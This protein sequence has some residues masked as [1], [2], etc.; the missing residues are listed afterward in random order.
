M[1]ATNG[2]V[3]GRLVRGK[4]FRVTAEDVCGMP[5]TTLSSYVD[6][7]LITV[8]ATKNEDSGDEIKVRIVDGT[9]DT[10]EPGQQTLLNFGIKIQLSKVDPGVITMLTGD[11]ATMNSNTVPLIDGWEEQAL[12]PV[13]AHFGFEVWTDTSG[14]VC[15]AGSKVYGYMLYPMVGQAYLTIDDITDK[16]CTVTINGM[17]YGNPSWGKGPY[18]TGTAPGR[19]VTDGVTT[20]AT[21]AFTSATAAFTSLDVGKTIVETSGAHIAPGTTIASV[22]NATTIVLSQ[23]ALGAGTAESVTI[24]AGDGSSISGPVNS[25][26]S[27]TPVPG[28][29]LVPVAAGAHRRFHIT[30]IAP[31]VSQATTGP[32]SIT[33]PTV[34]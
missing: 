25:A 2:S 18:G 28:R 3:V 17:S 9:I 10:Y 19:T 12:L 1:A 27:G 31:P 24:G 16:E 21:T 20:G 26:A 4:T 33:L 11:P 13:T 30:P 8:S 22:T 15:Q 7:G 29:L 23:A 5:L 32:V 14:S 34:Y 6:K